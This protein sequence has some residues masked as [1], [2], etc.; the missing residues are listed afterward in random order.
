MFSVFSWPISVL[1]DRCI[2]S[3]K[4][5][6]LLKFSNCWGSLDDFFIQKICLYQHYLLP[7][8]VINNLLNPVNSY[9][10]CFIYLASRK[11]NSVNTNHICRRIGNT[12]FVFFNIVRIFD[13]YTQYTLPNWSVTSLIN[14]DQFF[15]LFF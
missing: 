2:K 5:F 6:S 10:N 11:R 13:F 4:P 3:E 8:N 9:D 14:G 7:S 1:R 12:S 15:F